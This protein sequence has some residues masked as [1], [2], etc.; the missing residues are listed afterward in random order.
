MIDCRA[1][2]Q[3]RFQ[4]HVWVC[5]AGGCSV[6]QATGLPSTVEKWTNGFS[7]KDMLN[8]FI[9]IYMQ[10]GKKKKTGLLAP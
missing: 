10:M 4:T 5:E 1:T 9:A 6:F 8:F 3:R 2:E 7:V